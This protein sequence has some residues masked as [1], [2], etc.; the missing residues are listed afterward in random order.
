MWHFTYV[1]LSRLESI[2][3]ETSHRISLSSS[4]L[5]FLG[6]GYVETGSETSYPA[7]NGDLLPGSKA[8]GT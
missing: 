6:S 8:A 5:D 4:E 2:T 7:G 3:L 1:S